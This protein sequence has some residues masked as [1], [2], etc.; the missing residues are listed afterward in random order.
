MNKEVNATNVV[1]N[2]EELESKVT[3]YFEGLRA[4]RKEHTDILEL[5]NKSG[6]VREDSLFQLKLNKVYFDGAVD[7]VTTLLRFLATPISEGES[8]G[9]AIRPA[10]MEGQVIEA[11]EATESAPVPAQ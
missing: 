1:A 5:A 6:S 7:A 2:A 9:E 10:T 3:A 8:S 11:E 4:A